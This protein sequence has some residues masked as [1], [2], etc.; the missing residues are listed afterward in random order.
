[1]DNIVGTS[2]NENPKI[3]SIPKNMAIL[4]TNPILLATQLPNFTI[5]MEQLQAKVHTLSNQISKVESKNL[6]LNQTLA[7]NNTQ[8]ALHPPSVPSTPKF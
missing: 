8:E 7:R 6:I 3:G 4:S 2:S 1:L 5:L